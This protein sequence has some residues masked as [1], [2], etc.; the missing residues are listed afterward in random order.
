[1]VHRLSM[2]STKQ[3]IMLCPKRWSLAHDCCLICFVLLFR[4]SK[5]IHH[6][7]TTN[8]AFTCFIFL[9][10]AKRNYYLPAYLYLFLAAI[11]EVNLGLPVPSG[12]PLFSS[13]TCSVKNLWDKWHRFFVARLSFLSPNQQCQSTEGNTKHW[14]QTVSWPHPFFNHHQTADRM[15]VGPLWQSLAQ[16]Q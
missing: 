3:W 6:I 11:F 4:A 14:H 8:I 16:Y 2:A 7:T 1:M 10:I 5:F 13:S 9:H 12:S 15:G